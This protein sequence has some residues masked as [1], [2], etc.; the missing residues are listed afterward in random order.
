LISN[1]LSAPKRNHPSPSVN[2]ACRPLRRLRWIAF[3]MSP[4]ITM[5][6]AEFR[7]I[8]KTLA[9]QQRLLG[10]FKFDPAFFAEIYLT[11]QDLAET[12]AGH[13]ERCY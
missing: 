10:P 4:T 13:E 1:D 9:L 8:L 6:V 7:R 2:F 11:L 3:S 12:D 5:V